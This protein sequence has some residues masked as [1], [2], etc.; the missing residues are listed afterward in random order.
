MEQLNINRTSHCYQHI[1]VSMLAE[2]GINQMIIKES[3]G[4]TGAMT[5]TEKVYTHFDIKEFVN[6][7]SKT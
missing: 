6:A 7:I 3:V 4:H 2:A 5:L 1:C